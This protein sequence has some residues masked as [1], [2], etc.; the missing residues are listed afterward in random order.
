MDVALVNGPSTVGNRCV[1]GGARTLKAQAPAEMTSRRSMG[2][3]GGA[4]MLL[5][6]LAKNGSA[7]DVDGLAGDE[8]AVGRREEH[9]RADDVFRLLGALEDTVA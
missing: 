9:H 4:P 1:N 8:V 2:D 5:R 6:T 7:V 3:A